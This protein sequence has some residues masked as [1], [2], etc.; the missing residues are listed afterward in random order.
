MK[1][2]LKIKLASNSARNVK[3]ARVRVGWFEDSKYD[4]NT[5]IAL[6][7]YFQ[8]YGT[9]RGIPQRPFMRP[10]E[11]K[12]KAKWQQIALQEIRKCVESGRPL[13]QAMM[14]LGLAVQRDII[15]EIQTLTEPALNEKTVKARIRRLAKSTTKRKPTDSIDKPLIDTGIMLAALS[16]SEKSVRVEEK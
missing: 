4:D 8:E 5:P 12:N 2:Q 16:K 14:V 15:H 3:D 11:L 6:V 7:A 13:T 9:A 10:A 1:T